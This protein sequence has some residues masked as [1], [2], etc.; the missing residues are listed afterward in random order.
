MKVIFGLLAV[1]IV[2][3]SIFSSNLVPTWWT[4]PHEVLFG[5]HQ[6]DKLGGYGDSKPD[7]FKIKSPVYIPVSATLGTDRYEG[8]ISLKPDAQAGVKVAGAIVKGAQSDKLGLLEGKIT[9]RG[10]YYEITFSSKNAS[11]LFNSNH[12]YQEKTE[13][14]AI[15]EIRSGPQSVP[16]LMGQLDT[17][18]SRHVRLHP[19]MVGIEKPFL[20]KWKT[21]TAQ[22][23][24]DFEFLPLPN[25]QFSGTAYLSSSDKNCAFPIFGMPVGTRK[26]LIMTG[27]STTN[28]E[29]CGVYSWTAYSEEGP[30]LELKPYNHDDFSMTLSRK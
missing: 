7:L 9:D 16:F 1:Y 20:G 19:I 5:V 24:W 26:M 12:R 25:S 4:N 17:Q 10:S 15:L 21:Y 13:F 8:L 23:D 22:G 3:S 11:G 18:M 27:Q 30:V 6:H 2:I 14:P 28:D 29:Q